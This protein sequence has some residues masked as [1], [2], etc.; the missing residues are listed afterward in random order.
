MTNMIATLEKETNQTTEEKVLDTQQY[1]VVFDTKTVVDLGVSVYHE[2]QTK[3]TR[4]EIIE[5]AIGYFKDF[6]VSYIDESWVD[7]VEALNERQSYVVC[8]ATSCIEVRV[9]VEKKE[10]VELTRE[11]IIEKALTSLREDDFKEVITYLK[12]LASLLE[13]NPKEV[14]L[15]EVDKNWISGIESY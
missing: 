7:D 5:E 8:E 14:D 6:D 1:C 9:S 15:E 2:N 11:E 3:L 10:K 13:I 12:S 4:E